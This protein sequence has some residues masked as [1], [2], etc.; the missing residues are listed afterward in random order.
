M[1]SECSPEALSGAGTHPHAEETSL[2][3][4]PN[5]I[6]YDIFK[7]LDEELPSLALLSRRLHYIALPIYFTHRDV[8]IDLDRGSL[9]LHGERFA[10]L[11]PAL[12][13]ALFVKSVQRLH[14]RFGGPD[15]FTL[16]HI[17]QLRQLVGKLDRVGEVSLDFGKMTDY[18]TKTTS[19]MDWKLWTNEVGRLL[20]A[21]VTRGCTAL[22][23]RNGESLALLYGFSYVRDEVLETIHR[24]GAGFSPSGPHDILRRS[25]STMMDRGVGR[26]SDGLDKASFNKAGGCNVEEIEINSSMLFCQDFA[27]WT[28]DVINASPIRSLTLD[29]PWLADPG[30]ILPSLSIPKVS[31]L[32]IHSK[33]E[34]TDLLRFLDRHHT[35]ILELTVDSDL[36]VAT[37]TRKSGFGRLRDRLLNLD[38]F[39]A[40]KGILE[41]LT[42]LRA[43]PEYLI[44]LLGSAGALPSLDRV[45]ILLHVPCNERFRI[46]HVDTALSPVAPRLRHTVLSLKLFVECEHVHWIDMGH[47]A[48]GHGAASGQDDQLRL[49]NVITQLELNV[50]CSVLDF[51]AWPLRPDIAAF[52]QCAAQFSS[53][54][55]LALVDWPYKEPETVDFVERVANTCEWVETVGINGH[56]RKVSEWLALWPREELTGEVAEV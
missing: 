52:P 36:Y 24:S 13:L 54:K 41:N 14:C 47:D 43:T 32:L 3:H 42:T 55:E 25:F 4:L 31:K 37:D 6:L 20:G 21:I 2:L 56:M 50:P 19:G 51:L 39:R 7:D 49:L 45:T 1:S 34:Y 46:G 38:P 30:T 29:T 27:Q 23:V 16:K 11:L 22:S 48:P 10:E 17:Q 15:S 53:L 33:V 12:R 8:P 5:E 40:P 44:H 18:W 28:K 26:S 35:T 9:E